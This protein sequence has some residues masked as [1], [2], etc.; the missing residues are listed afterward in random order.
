[1]RVL[2]L[3]VDGY[4]GWPLACNL[5]QR[6]HEVYGL[7]NFTRRRLVYLERSAP[8]MPIVPLENRVKRLNAIVTKDIEVMNCD[9]SQDYYCLHNVLETFQPQVIYHLA[10]MPSAP[11]SMRNRENCQWSMSNNVGGTL[12]VLWAMR[13]CC[14]NAHLIKIGTMGEYGTPPLPI[15]EGLCEVKVR[16]ITAKMHFPRNAGSWY[17]QTK[18]HDTHNIRMACQQ[19]GLMCTDIMQGI[20]YGCHT[21]ATSK[22]LDL[23]TRLDFDECFGTA[24]NRFMVQAVVGHPLTVYGEGYQTRSVLPLQDSINCLTLVGE[25]IIP[26]SGEYREI[27]QFHEYKTIREMAQVVV[28][29]Y[30]ERFNKEPKVHYIPNPRIEQKE[31]FYQPISEVL[32]AIGYNN[33]MS[34]EQVVRLALLELH[35]HRDELKRYKKIIYPRIQWSGGSGLA[36]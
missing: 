12:N 2:I 20:V 11:W 24:I 27:N 14:P 15:P 21:T 3:G 26:E 32:P 34:M 28:G 25:R 33:S 13:E 31:H 9:V 16:G 7:D 36:N 1:M 18:V 23:R 10:E 30:Y 35:H 29:A 4:I 19:W 17:H 5:S 8:A 22:H 6:G